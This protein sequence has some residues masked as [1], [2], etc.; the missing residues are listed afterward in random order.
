ML[1]NLAVEYFAMGDSFLRHTFFAL[2]I[3][4]CAACFSVPASASQSA[5]NLGM[6]AYEFI[7][8]MG[9]ACSRVPSGMSREQLEE[10]YSPSNS[11]SDVIAYNSSVIIL[12]NREKASKLLR[13]VAVSY[14]FEQ[15]EHSENY[16]DHGYRADEE[17]VFSSICMQTLLALNNGMTVPEARAILKEIGLYGELLDGVQRSVRHEGLMY[18]MKLQPNGMAVMAVSHL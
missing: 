8:K 7:G 15:W 12:L 16:H 13:N 11:D 17:V 4:F 18:I 3:M 2:V 5:H 6:T 14:V 10:N 1:Y 9:Y